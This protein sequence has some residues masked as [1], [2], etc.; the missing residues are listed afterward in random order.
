[1]TLLYDL[2][3]STVQYQPL[4][5]TARFKNIDAVENWKNKILDRMR[6]EGKIPPNI[7]GLPTPAAIVVRETP[8]PSLRDLGT[9]CTCIYTC[10]KIMP[11]D[12]TSYYHNPLNLLVVYVCLCVRVSVCFVSMFYN[13]NI[14]AFV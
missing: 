12:I 2:G 7:H 11:Y 5:R 4:L 10:T 1:M 9:S 8:L 6:A 13:F 14:N 3:M